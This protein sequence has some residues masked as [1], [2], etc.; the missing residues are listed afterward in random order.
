MKQYK[1]MSFYEKEQVLADMYYFHLTSLDDLV[2]RDYDNSDYQ[3][4]YLENQ[5][6]CLGKKYSKVIHIVQATNPYNALSELE[7]EQVS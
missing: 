4:Y 6:Y 7:K 5:L 1:R 2:F 3:Y